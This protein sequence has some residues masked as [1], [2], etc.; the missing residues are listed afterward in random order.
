ML[1]ADEPTTALDV[2]IQAQI[3][4]LLRSIQHEFRTAMLFITHDLGVVAD[5]CD[6]VCVLYAGHVVEQASVEALFKRPCHPYTDGLLRSVPQSV[7]AGGRLVSI[8]GVVPTPDNMPNGCRFQ[9]RCPHAN[10]RCAELE[11]TLEPSAT[12]GLVRCCRHHEL[13]LGGE[14]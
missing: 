12:D 2:T 6:R 14:Q 8:P 1:I 9:P 13:R 3:L 7:A 11:P 5:V 10:G 4:E